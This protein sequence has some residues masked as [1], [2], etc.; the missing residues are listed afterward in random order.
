[1][2]KKI[3]TSIFAAVVFVMLLMTEHS[4][5]T[6]DQTDTVTKAPVTVITTDDLH[7]DTVSVTYPSISETEPE[8]EI[9]VP[10]AVSIEMIPNPD[11]VADPRA[12]LYLPPVSSAD[13]PEF[14]SD[15][16]FIG[17][18]V[19]VMLSWYAANTELS[20]AV[21]LTR[22]CYSMAHAANSTML[23]QYNGE[24]MT[25]EDALLASGVKKVFIMLG[26]NDLAA[27]GIPLTLEHWEAVIPRIREKCPDIQ[28]Y[29]QSCMP[30]W[31]GGEVGIL[32]NTEMDSL[33]ANLREFAE[34][35]EC[36]YID[37][38]SFMKDSTGG[39]ASIYCSDCY[40]HLTNEGADAWM[41]ILLAYAD[42]IM[43]S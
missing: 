29:I 39:L 12:P 40:V 19:S 21:F 6:N 35:W 10:C 16:A 22:E 42:A 32:N 23:V 15:A 41:R 7:E 26:T 37:I 34:A 13:A 31:T 8:P 28:I 17:D 11:A 25:P 30:I 43:V 18:S 24:E 36:F 9:T 20:D 2:A 3:T 38:S 5:I 4:F 14:Y 33:N 27:Y 1:M